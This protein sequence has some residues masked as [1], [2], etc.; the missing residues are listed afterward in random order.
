MVNN[1]RIATGNPSTT[2][3]TSTTRLRT[4]QHN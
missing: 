2:R 4:K 1:E 3:Y